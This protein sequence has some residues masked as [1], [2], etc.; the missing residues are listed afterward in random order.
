VPVG[1]VIETRELTKRFGSHRGIEGITLRVEPGEVFGLLGPNGAG[2]STLIRCLLGLIR[3][4]SGSCSVFGADSWRQRV[5]A[6]RRLGVLPSDFAYEPSMTGRQVVELFGRL[7]RTAVSA[8]AER[9]AA[10]L[11]ADLDRPLGE[12]SRGN[13]QKIGLVQALAH[14]PDLVV[15]DE[16]T[17]GL[18]PLMQ[19]EFLGL[20]DEMRAEGRTVVLSSHNMAEVERS[21]DR[22]AMVREGLLLEVEEVSSLLAR[23]P[24]HVRVVFDEAVDGAAFRAM[25]N[26][27]GVQVAGRAIDLLVSGDVGP[28]VRE[29]ARHAIA[30]F[31][32][33][34]PS[35]ERAFVE[36]YENGRRAAATGEGAA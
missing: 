6:H 12:L 3:P 23:S 7:R 20:V 30:E 15:L 34:R 9:L 13:H 8:E 1:S 5:Q 22:V 32:C 36:L 25:A 11:E 10:R 21:C 28:V 29:V 14:R 24:K 31:T 16:P 18:D 26:V 35:L 4:T 19:E 2:K 17:T 33:E 27:H